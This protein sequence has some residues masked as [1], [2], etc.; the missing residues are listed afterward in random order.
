MIILHI[1]I[2]NHI[3]VEFSSFLLEKRKEEQKKT[4]ERFQ[5]SELLGTSASCAHLPHARKVF[6]RGLG[7]EL[8]SKSSPPDNKTGFPL[9]RER[10]LLFFSG[11]KKSKQKKSH[12]ALSAQ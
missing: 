7:G 8:F 1:L 12:A 10:P 3:K 4:G 2:F 9:S 6:E 11:E 5:R